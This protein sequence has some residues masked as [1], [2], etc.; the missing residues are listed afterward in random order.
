M[1]SDRATRRLAFS[2]GGGHSVMGDTVRI[3]HFEGP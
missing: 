1:M 3:V 2:L